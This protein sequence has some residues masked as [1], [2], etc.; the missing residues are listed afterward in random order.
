MTR[1]SLSRFF[2]DRSEFRIFIVHLGAVKRGAEA[3]GGKGPCQLRGACVLRDGKVGESVSI[4]RRIGALRAALAAAF[5]FGAPAGAVR[6]Q[7]PLPVPSSPADQDAKFRAFVISF[8]QTALA[9]GI[10][11]QIYDASVTGL[12]RD[13]RVETLNLQQPEFTKP[14]W[15]YLA[16]AV[17][18]ARIAQGQALLAD[19][20]QMLSAIE[21]RFGV[22]KE[23]LV[24][25]WGIESDYG[26]EMGSFDIFDALATLAYDGPRSDFGRRELVDALQIEQQE[27]FATAEMTSSWAG[28]FGQTQ[29]VPSAFLRYA[30][31]GDGDGRRDLWHSAA[32]SLASAA[33][34]LAQSGWERGAPWGYQVQLP[35]NFAYEY[36]DPDRVSTITAWR[37]LGVRGL[38]GWEL[39]VSEA[40][41]AIYLPA[42]ARGPAFMVFD[43][44]RTVLKYNNAGSYALAVCTLA[45]R[46]QGHAPIE[47]SWPTD[48]LPLSRSERI[49]L[50][51]N[52]V[53]LG[54]DSGAADG[55]LGP[56]AR[57]ALR[58]YQKSRGLV[59]DAFATEALLSRMEREQPAAAVQSP[60]Q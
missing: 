3:S 11:P 42:G 47:A 5:L 21:Q 25:V 38:G 57:A 27:H 50:Q 56:K 53:R 48:E 26:S 31:D 46:M 7:T 28:A 29:F 12:T 20:A 55:I 44:F 19:D 1:Q 45:D 10:A 18:A 58:A 8:R 32:D 4:C 49:A 22:Q 41:A 2:S 35:S 59:P 40:R 14:I 6:A 13:P 33:N 43:N 52:L 15:Q 36:A 23:I 60:V 34:L 9:A 24:A 30:V 17:S 39:P 51:T 37:N 16:G 54:F